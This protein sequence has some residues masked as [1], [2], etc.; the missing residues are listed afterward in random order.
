MNA[1]S[2]IT[3]REAQPTALDRLA[4]AIGTALVAWSLRREIRPQISHEQQYLRELNRREVE[5]I[6]AARD[7]GANQLYRLG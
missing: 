4:L 2:T 5:H 3:R 6:T 1:A 7:L